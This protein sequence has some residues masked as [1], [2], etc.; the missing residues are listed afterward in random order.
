MHRF[1]RLPRLFNVLIMRSMSLRQHMRCL[2]DGRC[3][4]L[5]PQEEG[6]TVGRYY[7]GRYRNY[8]YYRGSSYQIS[9]RSGVVSPTTP[10]PL[11]VAAVRPSAPVLN[12]DQGLAGLSKD[13][14]E[15][16]LNLDDS[17][18]AGVFRAYKSIHGEK[19]TE[20]ARRT[21]RRWKTGEVRMSG[22]IS[23]RLL[24]FVPRF[25][26]VEQ[27]YSLLKSLWSHVRK[28]RV[29]RLAVS[30]ADQVTAAVE[31][32]TRETELAC[33]QELPPKIEQWL[34]WLSDNDFEVA[35]HLLKDFEAREAAISSKALSDKLAEIFRLVDSANGRA[36]SGFSSVELPWGIVEIHVT[37]TGRL[38]R[39]R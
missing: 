37:S 20:Y 11:P 13:V 29:L 38:Q 32:V 27:K 22:E 18:L 33:Q 30:S 8:G 26:S 7:H 16:F 2:P 17:V 10:L 21:Y 39:E 6:F 24:A 12:E 9:P 4:T 35:K 25:L 34:A 36:V 31:A 1:G 19:K 23:R 3:R 15:L 5:I 14:R 28:G